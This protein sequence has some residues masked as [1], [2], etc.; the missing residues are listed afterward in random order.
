MGRRVRRAVTTKWRHSF[1]SELPR[2]LQVKQIWVLPISSHSGDY[3]TPVNGCLR[4]AF[5]KA[6]YHFTYSLRGIQPIRDQMQGDLME[7]RFAAEVVA[8]WVSSRQ[9]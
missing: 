5:L 8:Q 4:G 6:I 9:R 3:R 1:F 7:V 2:K